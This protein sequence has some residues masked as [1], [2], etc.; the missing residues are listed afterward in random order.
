MQASVHHNWSLSMTDF[1]L[2]IIRNTDRVMAS[3]EHDVFLQWLD[4]ELGAG[5]LSKGFRSEQCL[6]TITWGSNRCWVIEQRLQKQVTS[7]Y[8][9]LLKN[10]VLGHWSR[11]GSYHSINPFTAPACKISGLKSAHIHPCK[12]HIWWSYKKS[13]FN[14]VHFERSPLT[15]SFEGKKAVKL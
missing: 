11:I 12:Q 1:H 2:C 7:F 13:T 15:C 8:K 3:E 6:S 10:W 14:P 9:Q 4:A 5:S